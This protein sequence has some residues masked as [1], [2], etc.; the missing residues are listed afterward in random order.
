MARQIDALLENIQHK[1]KYTNGDLVAVV[2]ATEQIDDLLEQEEKE[3]QQ[4]VM[5][6]DIRTPKPTCEKKETENQTKKET[7]SDRSRLN[8]VEQFL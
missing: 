8:L 1:Q 7:A 3:S 2:L 5:D 4:R 6:A